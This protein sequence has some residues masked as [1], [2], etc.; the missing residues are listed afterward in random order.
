MKLHYLFSLKQE[1]IPVNQHKC[2]LI[3][4]VSNKFKV[5][6]KMSKVRVDSEERKNEKVLMKPAN[7]DNNFWLW[8]ETTKTF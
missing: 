3:H 2:V 1:N 6:S 5:Y 8:L 4:R 7:S